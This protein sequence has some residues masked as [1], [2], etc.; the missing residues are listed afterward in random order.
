MR[1]I[2]KD[3]VRIVSETLPEVDPIY[4]FGALQVPGQEE[5]ADLRP[6]FTGRDYFGCDIQ[7]GPGVDH[8]LNL[9][10]ID[11]PPESVGTVLLLD[12]LE[13]VEFC[14]KALEEVF[15]VLKPNGFLVISSVMKFPIHNYPHDYWRFT[16]EGFKSLLKHFA[17]SFVNS[18]GNPEFPHTIVGVASK[19][20]PP[21][22][23][24]Y[25]FIKKIEIWKQFWSKTS[26]P[27]WK[28]TMKPF[29]P[30]V[31]SAIYRKIEG[32]IIKKRS[33]K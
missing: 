11:L 28:K 8:I 26:Q 21:D 9:H 33:V 1:Q 12:T 18:V 15:R 29:V 31:F 19:I 14:R 5:F 10:H 2:I 6:F 7:E 4:E 32:I 25:E 13:H 23:S 20:L 17:F 27:M 30:P 22:N 3:F 24:N 16:P